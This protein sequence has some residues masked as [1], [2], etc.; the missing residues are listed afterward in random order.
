MYCSLNDY[1][2]SLLKYIL[3]GVKAGYRNTSFK[4]RF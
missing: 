3:G 1:T 2:E 4:H